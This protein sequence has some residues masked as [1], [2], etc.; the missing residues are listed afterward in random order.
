[1]DWEEKIDKMTFEDILNGKITAYYY[2]FDKSKNLPATDDEIP[3]PIRNDI[4]T[5]TEITYGTYGFFTE[6]METGRQIIAGVTY[7]FPKHIF[8]ASYKENIASVI[9]SVLYCFEIVK[10]YPNIKKEE[11]NFSMRYTG[12]Y[13]TYEFEAL[14]K[15]KNFLSMFDN[16]DLFI[17][18]R[19]N[20]WKPKIY[21]YDNGIREMKGFPLSEKDLNIIRKRTNVRLH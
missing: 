4:V 5:F 15:N 1:M 11:K 14:K 7:V 20:R 10:A 9:D 3:G 6:P 16:G 18:G 21:Y 12:A 17:V 13:Y 19:G 8:T 2:Q